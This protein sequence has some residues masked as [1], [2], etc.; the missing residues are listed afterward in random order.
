LRHNTGSQAVVT[1][2]QLAAVS[3]AGA[4]ADDEVLGGNRSPRDECSTEFLQVGWPLL[5]AW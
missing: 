5:A 2:A 4:M 1:V 3:D